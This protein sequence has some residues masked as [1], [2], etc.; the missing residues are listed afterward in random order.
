MQR[1]IARL[2][3][4]LRAITATVTHSSVYKTIIPRF[5]RYGAWLNQYINFHQS[6][7]WLT[8]FILLSNALIVRAAGEVPDLPDTSSIGDPYQVAD[9]VRLLS[10][11]TPNIDEKPDEL[12]T[13]FEERLNGSFISTNPLIAT[14]PGETDEPEQ[15][16][17]PKATAPTNRGKEIK[18]TVAIGDTLSGIGERYGVKVATI[19]LANNLSD[20]DSIKPGQEIKIPADDLS[21][22][23]IKAAQER[24]TASD[25]LKKTGKEA[26]KIGNAGAPK[27]GYG[28]ITPLHHNGVSRRLVGGHTGV[29]YRANIGTPIMAAASGVVAISDESGY[30]GG[31]GKTVLI[32]HGGG[33]TTRYGHMNDVIVSSGQSVVQGQII[34]Y[35]GNTGRS[36]GPHLHFELRINGRAVDPGV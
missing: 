29:D 18:Y 32:S 28:L 1:A 10:P 24:K 13:T 21:D 25:T 27:G 14:Q 6:I 36:T 4:I 15:K 31:Y 12:A 3:A 9:T 22:K 17:T 16:P 23:A 30:N 20:A 8:A 35:S 19:K 7:I 34:G 33:K 26:V 5:Q 11:Y 2:V